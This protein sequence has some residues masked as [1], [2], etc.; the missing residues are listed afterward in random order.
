M[1][2]FILHRNQKWGPPRLALNLCS[3]LNCSLVPHVI[4]REHTLPIRSS[5]VLSDT[6]APRGLLRTYSN[7]DFVARLC[8][9]DLLWWWTV[10]LFVYE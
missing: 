6:L 2:M 8:P 10:R 3:T 4:P 1:L 9:D 5:P 7:A